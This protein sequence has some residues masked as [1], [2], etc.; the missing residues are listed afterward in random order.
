[1]SA[2]PKPAPPANESLVTVIIALLANAL[3]AVAK[4]IVAMITGAASMLAEAAH[5]WAD[6]GNELLLLVAERRSQRKP[7]SRHPLGYGKDAYIW[8]M[9]AAFGLFT[10]GSVVS[11]QHGIQEL[12][13]PEP[14]GE[15]GLAYAVLAISFVLEGISFVRAFGQARQAARKRAASTL[16]HVLESS[17]PTL[18]AVFAEDAAALIGLAIAAAGI[19]LHEITGSPVPDAIGSILV[20]ILLGVIAVVLIARNRAFLLGEAVDDET[21]GAILAE[22]LAEPRIERITFLHIEYTGPGTVFLVAAVDLVGDEPEAAV[23]DRLRELE[24]HIE[25]ER[26]HIAVAVFTLSAP[27][28]PAL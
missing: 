24:R 17:N 23:A 28:A 7:D 4:T 26:P 10:V 9:F 3:I 25:A 1:M 11:I 13:D 14:A 20:G 5:S 22:L 27:G 6:T 16:E 18:R 19:A 15:F 8:S 12:L 21:R 2:E